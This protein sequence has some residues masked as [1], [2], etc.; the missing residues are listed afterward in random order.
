M[1]T[2]AI[3]A[4]GAAFRTPGFLDQVKAEWTKIRSARALYVQVLLALALGIGLS[5]LISLAIASSWDNISATEKARFEPEFAGLT[6][7]A[8]SGVVVVVTGVTLV[9]SEYTSGMVRLTMTITPQRLRVLFAKALVI[10]FVTWT[11]GFFVTIGAFFASQAVLGTHAGVPTASIGDSAAKRAIIAAWLTTPVFPLL[12]A[13]IGSILRSTAGAI[14][15]TL[16]L[17]FGPGIFGGLLPAWWQRN[18][19]AY[20]PNNA[21]DVLARSR[22]DFVTHISPEAAIATLLVWLGVAFVIA[23]VMLEKRDV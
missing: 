6:G 4:S 14:T 9:S 8:F 20:F 13:A 18:I 7:L 21:S 5:A 15:A 10:A 22:T 1:A 17:F 23:G 3:P 19:L 2:A 12:G 11:I 16:A